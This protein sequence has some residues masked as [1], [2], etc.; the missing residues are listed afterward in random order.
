MKMRKKISPYLRIGARLK[1]HLKAEIHKF[2]ND[3]TA[4]RKKIQ[5]KE[6]EKVGFYEITRTI[7]TV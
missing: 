7:E 1:K 5:D 4:F 6:K 2:L 3:Y